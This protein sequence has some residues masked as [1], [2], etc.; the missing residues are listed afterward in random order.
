[1]S[2][3]NGGD[4]VVAKSGTSTSFRV[5][6]S[7]DQSKLTR[8][9]DA[10]QSAQVAG[11]DRQYVT[12]AS[13][14]ITATPVTQED[15]ATTLRVPVTSVPKAISET[16]TELSGFNNKKGT[17]SVSGHGLDQGDTATGYHS[18]LVPVRVRCRGSGRRLHRQR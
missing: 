18:E 7:I 2:G 3:D 4:T 14:I 12:D 17:L 15:D 8:T 16:T 9:R 13:G 1:M 5:K 6:I 10:T 11:K